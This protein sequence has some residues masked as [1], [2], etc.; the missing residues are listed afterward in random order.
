[1]T[2]ATAGSRTSARQTRKLTRTTRPPDRPFP[3]ITRKQRCSVTPRPVS[4]RLRRTPDLRT[5]RRYSGTVR[6]FLPRTAQ[7]SSLALLCSTTASSASRPDRL[8]FQLRFREYTLAELA[9]RS[10]LSFGRL[11]DV[12]V[13]R[14]GWCG[15]PVG[16][17]STVVV[18]AGQAGQ[19]ACP[20]WPP[21]MPTGLGGIRCPTEPGGRNRRPRTTVRPADALAGLDEFECHSGVRGRVQTRERVRA[22]A[23]ASSSL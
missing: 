21:W 5:G 3:A 17:E 12:P 18:L 7:G 4:R 1:M 8:W 23:I 10:G 2:N 15:R 19:L 9:H 14:T 16:G 11:R 20:Y 13:C 22:V 6:P